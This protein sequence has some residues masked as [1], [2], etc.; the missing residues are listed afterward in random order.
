MVGRVGVSVGA[1]GGMYCEV[2][3]AIESDFCGVVC[4]LRGCFVSKQP[5]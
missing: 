3:C 2:V 4:V 1:R 5:C